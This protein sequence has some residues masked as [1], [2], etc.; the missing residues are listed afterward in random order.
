MKY[1]LECRVCEKEAPFGDVEGINESGWNEV[2]KMGLT[3]G[4]W[5]NQGE[6][7]YRHRAYCPN[8]SF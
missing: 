3:D 6:T 2:S 4:E 5:S 1:V 8:H 7:Y